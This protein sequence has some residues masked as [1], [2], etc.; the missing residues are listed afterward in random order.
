MKHLNNIAYLLSAARDFP[1]MHRYPAVVDNTLRRTLRH[2]STGVTLDAKSYA[3]P[4]FVAEKKAFFEAHYKNV[5]AQQ[6]AAPAAEAALLQQE[7][8]NAAATCHK[9]DVEERVHGTDHGSHDLLMGVSNFEASQKVVLHITTQTAGHSSAISQ[10]ERP[11]H[12]K[13]TA[14]C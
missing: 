7:E 8:A 1:Y 13:W 9:S 4:G 6:A 12:P 5:I 14:S 10:V 3:Q 11:K 2:P